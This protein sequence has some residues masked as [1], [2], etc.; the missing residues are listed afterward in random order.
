M[1]YVPTEYDILRSTQTVRRRTSRETI[2]RWLRVV[3]AWTKT[4]KQQ[5]AR[6]CKQVLGTVYIICVM[7][8][9]TL[10]S[11]S[12]VGSTLRH[13]SK[14]QQGSSIEHR[15]SSTPP[16]RSESE[17]AV[18]AVV[19]LLVG[20]N[21]IMNATQIR[22]AP[23]LFCPLCVYLATQHSTLTRNMLFACFIVVRST[24]Y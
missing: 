10:A 13:S 24:S 12:T 11:C 8:A 6:K 7:L 1:V 19:V 20:N 15:A 5:Q 18:A 21:N 17:E 3:C 2:H 14:Q 16:S 23:T 22:R 9:S 4:H